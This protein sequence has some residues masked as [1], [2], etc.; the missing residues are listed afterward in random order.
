MTPVLSNN[1]HEVH[2]Y[3]RLSGIARGRVLVIMQDDDMPP[4]SCAWLGYL[5]A[6]FERFPLL[7][8]LGAPP[9]SSA[10]RHPMHPSS[11]SGAEQQRHVHRDAQRELVASARCG[12]RRVYAPWQ[13]HAQRRALG[14]L[15]RGRQLPRQRVQASPARGD[16]L[17]RS[18]AR[19]VLLGVGLAHN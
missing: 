10:P 3:N 8:A 18:A 5:L 9:C 6:E 17:H 14:A 12:G 13:P 2:G 1:L 19:I 15:P 11:R 4:D 16:V 7:G